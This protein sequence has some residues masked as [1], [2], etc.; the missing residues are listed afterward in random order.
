M[1]VHR[2]G[3]INVAFNGSCNF[4]HNRRE[5]IQEASQQ[6]IYTGTLSH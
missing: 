3:T 1:F 2:L 6:Y 5:V 4:F